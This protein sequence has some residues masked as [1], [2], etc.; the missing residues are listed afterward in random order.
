[1]IGIDKFAVV[2]A[3]AQ[4]KASYQVVDRTGLYTNRYEDGKSRKGGKCNGTAKILY[5]G[6][7]GHIDCEP[8]FSA[9]AVRRV[10]KYRPWP[11]VASSNDKPAGT[12]SHSS[13]AAGF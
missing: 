3:A 5:Q 8:S 6:V 7:V 12:R 9:I 4:R 1:V 13:P 2:R 11:R 10:N